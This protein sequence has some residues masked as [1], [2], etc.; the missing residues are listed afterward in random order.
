MEQVRNYIIAVMVIFVVIYGIDSILF[1]HLFWERLVANIGI[2]LLFII[3]YLNITQ[4]Q[5]QESN[6]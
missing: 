1:R 2:V 6:L 5:N 3:I 4:D